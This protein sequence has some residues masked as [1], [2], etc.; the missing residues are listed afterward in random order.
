[1]SASLPFFRLALWTAVLQDNCSL[2]Q[3]GLWDP[4]A[5]EKYSPL[6][7][8]IV[9]SI[10]ID[11]AQQFQVCVM[12]AIFGTRIGQVDGSWSRVCRRRLHFGTYHGPQEIGPEMTSCAVKN[13]ISLQET[14]AI[15]VREAPHSQD[16]L[17]EAVMCS[18]SVW[19]MS[20]DRVGW[21]GAYKLQIHP[22]AQSLDP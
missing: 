15:E 10:R 17:A 14:P 21:R 16:V 3:L 20:F 22:L 19:V 1:M 2:A 5:A 18:S 12:P 7:A 8:Q 11:V 13:W 9:G 6:E 4:R